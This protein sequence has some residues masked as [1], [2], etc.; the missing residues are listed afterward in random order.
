MP[1]N[2]SELLDLPKAER[3]RYLRMFPTTRTFVFHCME[4]HEI[5]FV[6]RMITR[7]GGIYREVY[8]RPGVYWVATFRTHRARIECTAALVAWLNKA[9]MATHEMHRC[10]TDA[11][12]EEM[13][14]TSESIAHTGDVPAIKYEIVNAIQIH[15][16][17]TTKTPNHP[18]KG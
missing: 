18:I 17:V 2:V 4:P 10:L 8:C 1:M 14:Y 16:P 7:Y 5:Q 11:E 3:S 9:L 6:R 12:I 15:E 13:R